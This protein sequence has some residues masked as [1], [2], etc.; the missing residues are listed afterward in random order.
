MPQVLKVASVSKDAPADGVL[1]VDDR[2][3][4]VNGTSVSS[5]PDVADDEE[6]RAL[7]GGAPEGEPLTIRIQRDDRTRTVSVT[8]TVDDGR[9]VIGILP[10]YDYDF[11]IDVS[12]NI[13]PDIG[14]PS[15]GLMFSLAVYDTLTAGALTGDHVV[16][17]TGEISSDGRVG[18]IGGIQQ[19]IAGARQSGADLFLVPPDNCEDALGADNGDMRLAMATTMHDARLALEKYAEDAEADLPSCEDAPTDDTE[20]AGS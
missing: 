17:G 7:I 8:P 4:A 15:A 20:D 19:K 2:L 5:D 12:I 6:L 11:P 14:G 18:A 10:G 3:L 9:Q 1:Q 13:S 16:A